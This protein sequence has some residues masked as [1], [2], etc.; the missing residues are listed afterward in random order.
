ML[1][2]R[3][4]HAEIGGKEILKGVSLSVGQ[5]EMHVLMGPNGSGK[6]TF[7]NAIAGNPALKCTGKVILNGEDIS[8][9]APDV[10]ARKGVFLA[11]Q[12]PPEI[13][14]LA[15]GTMLLKT[16]EGR[17]QG[18][19]ELKLLAQRLDFSD[20]F[21]SRALNKGLSGGEKK[22]SELLQMLAMAPKIAMLDEIDSGLDADAVRTAIGAVRGAREK[23]S[24]LIITHH[25]GIAAAL[26]PDKV[27]IM[28]GG[29]IVK[30][31]GAEIAKE[32]GKRGFGANGKN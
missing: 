15:L 30:S 27:H 14:G 31:G 24:F 12:S 4:L 1:E 25:A 8:A 32:I 21:L 20:S 13:N 7:A 2:I 5:G 28:R 16:E 18:V 10:R 23:T 19:G 6:S 9:L 11:F 29:K 3:D 22:K 17:K 26:V